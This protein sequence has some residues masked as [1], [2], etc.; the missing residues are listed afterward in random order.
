MEKRK[1]NS[2][3]KKEKCHR[4]QERNQALTQWNW[5]GHGLSYAGGLD[6]ASAKPDTLPRLFALCLGRQ[7]RLPLLKCNTSRSDSWTRADRAYIPWS[8]RRG[9]RELRPR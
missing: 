8:F 4:N 3:G 1:E 5:I 9:W 6:S 2:G 7:G